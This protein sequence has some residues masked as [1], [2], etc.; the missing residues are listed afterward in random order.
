MTNADKVK[1]MTDDE[2]ASLIAYRCDACVYQYAECEVR[3]CSC[4]DGVHEWLRQE[5]DDD[6]RRQHPAD[7]GRG[8]TG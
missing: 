3:Y 2:L 8:R 6:K 1:R 4:F 7:D 5:A